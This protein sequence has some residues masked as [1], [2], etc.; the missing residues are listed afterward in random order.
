VTPEYGSLSVVGGLGVFVS[1]LAEALA[2]REDVTVHVITPY[3]ATSRAPVLP[4]DC[5]NGDPEW[6]VE[7][8][9]LD[10]GGR[11][12]AAIA[13]LHSTRLHGVYVHLLRCKGHFEAGPYDGLG[14]G[15]AV[16][17]A[18]G[19]VRALQVSELFPDVIVSNDWTT[20][21]VA[22]I[23]RCAAP[24]RATPR[25][26]CAERDAAAAIKSATLIH[27]IHNLEAGYDGALEATQTE[28]ARAHHVGVE[29]ELLAPTEGWAEAAQQPARAGTSALGES[30]SD[31]AVDVG[32]TRRSPARAA[33]AGAGARGS[34]R[35]VNLSHTHTSHRHS[36]NG[37]RSVNLS[38]AALLCCDR[39]ATVGTSYAARLE[40]S[41]RLAPL[42]RV[43]GPPLVA[44]AAI[45]VGAHLRRLRALAP[46][47][48][49]AAKAALQLRCFGP[50]GVLADCPLFAY[51]GRITRQKGV[52]LLLDTFPALLDRHGGNAQLLVCGRASPTDRYAQACATQMASLQARFP[53]HFWARPSEFCADGLQL[54]LAADLCVMPSLFEPAGLVQ[55]EFLAAGTPIVASSADGLR[56]SLVDFSACPREGCA[57]LFH[58]HTH[59]ALLD[60]LERALAAYH[61]PSGRVWPALQANASRSA[62]DVDASARA[63]HLELLQMRR[64]SAA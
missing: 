58:A 29:L 28:L 14:L 12:P 53:A 3:W 38:R 37:S 47:S 9:T 61:E 64:L 19:A 8:F 1:H 4:D 23:I 59:D 49:P 24:T 21:L 18:L 17:L 16:V 36:V 42:L 7:R 20:A 57:F 51:V 34:L 40:R 31:R 46:S 62:L 32:A 2:R 26:G 41:S 54:N 6:R 45:P 44:P 25:A 43:K 55:H 30:P 52:H 39:W 5:C 48:P 63:W 22:P 11:S 50:T 15:G 27:L 60:A 56:D 35:S 13:S 10:L 33:R